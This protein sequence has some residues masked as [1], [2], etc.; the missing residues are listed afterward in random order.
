[1]CIWVLLKVYGSDFILLGDGQEED[2]A[3][4]AELLLQKM[5]YVHKTAPG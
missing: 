4:I 5:E 1:M 2:R 3:R